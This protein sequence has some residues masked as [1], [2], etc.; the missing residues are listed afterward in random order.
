M[1]AL[2]QSVA[3]L[4]QPAACSITECLFFEE[5]QTGIFFGLPQ[6]FSA[7][8]LLPLLSEHLPDAEA[9]VA[10]SSNRMDKGGWVSY[11]SLHLKFTSLGS[12]TSH[13]KDNIHLGYHG[14][15]NAL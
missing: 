1:S 9:G 13:S 10:P 11:T 8:E 4:F 6:R 3:L 2:L 5:L 14:F 7:S 12:Q 15:S